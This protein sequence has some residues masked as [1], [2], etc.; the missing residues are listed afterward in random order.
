MRHADMAVDEGAVEDLATNSQ[1]LKQMSATNELA[2]HATVGVGASDYIA[3]GVLNAF[4]PEEAQVLWDILDL[5]DIHPLDLFPEIEF[6]LVVGRISQQG[7]LPSNAVSS[8]FHGY[9]GLHTS[10]TSSAA[11]SSE[12]Q[13]LLDVPSGPA[14]WA[15]LPKPTIA[16]S[17]TSALTS[18]GFE[19]IENLRVSIS[20]T[21][22]AAGEAFDLTVI[23]PTGVVISGFI[24]VSQYGVVKSNGSQPTVRVT[25]PPTASGSA[26]F[27]VAGKTPD[28][29]LY[30]A[31]EFTVNVVSSHVVVDRIQFD[32]AEIRLATRSTARLQLVAVQGDQVRTVTD[33]LFYSSD[34]NTITVDQDGVVT[35]V[36][37]GY[38]VVHGL[39][40]GHVATVGVR[41]ADTRKH[42][43]V[44]H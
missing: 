20:R 43:A 16:G 40:A 17:I 35:A 23:P 31:P 28:G 44:S 4:A 27:A 2:V 3:E 30:S 15:D 39:Y 18:R 5:F 29:T 38:A 13:R 6:D 33:A 1:A 22:V 37:A 42:R 10:N 34:P 7:G 41:V 12:V 8:P 21:T 11:Y 26:K 19:S 14:A 9:D 36:Q 25:V 32:V 24:V